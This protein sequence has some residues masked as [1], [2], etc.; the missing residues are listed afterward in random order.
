MCL[1]NSSTSPD[2]QQ[3][4]QQSQEN[5]KKS[6]ENLELA[7]QKRQTRFKQLSA[8]IAVS[9]DWL[10]NKKEA[11]EALEYL[12]QRLSRDQQKQF[13]FG[14]FPTSSG[15]LL[16]FADDLSFLL[17]SN[18][19]EALEQTEVVYFMKTKVKPFY[20]HHPLLIPY[21]DVYGNPVSIAGRTLLSEEEMKAKKI[22]KYKNLPFLRSQN[23][24]GLNY[25]Y[26]NIVRKRC[27]VVVEGQFDWITSFIHGL[28]NVVALCGSKIGQEH[29]L[30]LKRYTTRLFI[31]LDNDEAGDKGWNAIKKKEAKWEI[32]V[33]RLGL[34]SEFK[35]IDDA[36]KKKYPLD[37]I[38][39]L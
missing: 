37:R 39:S 28:N 34:P 24:F 17:K 9:Q 13:N 7:K 33:D 19:K 16:E 20:E 26:R 5:E 31:L 2:D 14:Y 30:L 6:R 4:E 23:L 3:T 18:P 1:E 15:S 32:A 36:I 38:Y 11:T 10:Y 35:D 8:I 12:D 21:Y 27:V 29:I 22:S 25:S